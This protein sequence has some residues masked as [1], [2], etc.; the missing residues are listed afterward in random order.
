MEYGA[1]DLHMRRSQIRIVEE[2][3]RVVL[4]R[5]IDTTR[6]AFSELF[7]GRAPLRILVEASTEAEWV[8][9][10]LEALGHTVIVADPNYALMY[11][12][13]TRRVKTDLRDTAA[14]AEACRL[15]IYRAVHR[16]SADQ[17][18]ERQRQT[19]RQQLVRQRTGL[20]NVCR[21]LLRQEGYRLRGGEAETIEARLTD[22][23]L[24]APLEAILAPIRAVL[25]QLTARL[26]ELDAAARVRA[27]AD[28]IVRHL[29]TA[30]GVGPIVAL[31]FRAV[32]DTPTRF[33][34]NA[35]RVA[36]YLGLV[37]RE[38]SSGERQRKGHITKVGPPVLR[39]L[40]VQSAWT[41]W[42]SRRTEAQGLRGWADALAARRGRRIAVVAL[43]R[44]LARMLYAMWRDGTVFRPRLRAAA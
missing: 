14:L 30:P 44:R 11:G 29:M 12:Q 3:G 33:H 1:I 37:P 15:G 32:L 20:I 40:L 7:G 2:D 27:Q 19:V 35:Q 10:C 38:A 16:V 8:A 26:R 9:Q 39:A 17:W 18:R 34:G 21:A 28:P 36:A 31:T 43:A 5:R 42:R 4:D 24:S 23:A 13:R 6:R 25:Q 41:L 22:V